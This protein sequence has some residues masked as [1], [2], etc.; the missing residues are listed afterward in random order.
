[1]FLYSAVCFDKYVIFLFCF[2]FH[3]VKYCSSN[4][5]FLASYSSGYLLKRFSLCSLAFKFAC[6]R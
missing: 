1:M 6:I 5:F 4:F 2:E 3:T